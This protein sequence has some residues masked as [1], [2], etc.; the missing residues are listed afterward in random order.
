MQGNRH[1]YKIL[2]ENM[3]ERDHKEDVNIDGRI[4]LK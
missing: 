1:A 2:Q 3:K 4:I